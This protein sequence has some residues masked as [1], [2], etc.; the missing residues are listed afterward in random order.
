MTKSKWRA[1]KLLIKRRFQLANWNFIRTL[2]AAHFQ[3]FS[4]EIYAND[5]VFDQSFS[6]L[7]TR[8]QM[9]GFVQLKLIDF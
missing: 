2:L 5:S 7:T 6:L 1:K 4:I 3:I 8:W 9:L